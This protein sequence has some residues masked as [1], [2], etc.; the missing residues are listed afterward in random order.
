[1]SKVQKIVILGTG[2]YAPVLAEVIQE[3][4]GI[5]LAGFIENYNRD[6]CYDTICGMRI[7]WID[8]A[9]SMAASC[10]AVCCLAT[11]Q[12]SQFIEQARRMGFDFATIIHPSVRV[13]ASA[14][15]G[16]GCI[17]EPGVILSTKDS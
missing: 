9:A 2:D 13:P 11:T 10:K 14:K 6:R 17:L 3:T 5:E 7:T 1:M 4:P 12:R 8:D 15:I 16:Q